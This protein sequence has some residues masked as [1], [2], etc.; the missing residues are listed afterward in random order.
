MDVRFDTWD[1]RCLYGA[2]SLTTAAKEISKY[3]L[4]L[5]GIQE[6]KWDGGSAESVGENTFF[7]RKGGMRIM[8]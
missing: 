8:N 1:V 4:D 6:V 7:N 2:G 5:M 3:K